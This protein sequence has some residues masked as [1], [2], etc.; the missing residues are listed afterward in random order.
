M[1]DA[2]T[3]AIIGAGPVGLAAAAHL[4][5]RGLAPI[6][7]EAGPEAGHAVRQWQQVQLFSPW[8][9]NVDKAAA[10]LLAP[11]G[12]NSPDPQ[13]YP[14]GGELLDRYLTPLATRTPLRD[15]IR[16]SS[17]VS[18]ISRVGFDKVKSEGREQAP[19]EIRY[20]NGKG[21]EVLRADAVIDTSGTWF[22]PNPAGSNGLPAIGERDYAGRIAYGMPDVR[23]AARS[24]YAGKTVAVLGA[25]HSAV[26]TL[27]DLVHLA[28]EAAGTQVIWLLRGA[29]PAKAFGGGRN[30]KLAARGELGSTFAALVAA[31]KIRVETGFGVTHLSESEGRLRIAAGGCCGA[32]SVVA[33]ELIV[34]TGFRP[35]F[36]FLSELRLRLDPAI[37]APLALAPLI[38]PNEHSC[39]TVRPHGARELAHDERGFYLAGMKSYGR[40]PT[41]LMMTGYEQVRSIAAELAGDKAAAA[42]VELVLPETGVC[43]RGGVEAAGAEPGCCG[44]AAKQE[45]SACCAA[46]EAAKTSGAS[47]CGCS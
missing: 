8:E 28:D 32:R 34:S 19:F 1:S 14:T 40:A 24:R 29:D 43:T 30:D 22:S 16:T 31:G 10:R 27:I 37:E 13:S 45:A 9:Y 25:G 39:G 18:A 17:R 36:S 5:E 26:G 3:V 42:R 47:G 38:D 15:V 12:W 41:F 4:R 33:D 6:V 35:D 23:G 7:L 21:P 46:D 11:T 44:G 20:Q 2:K